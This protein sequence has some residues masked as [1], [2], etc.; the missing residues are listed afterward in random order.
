VQQDIARI[1][2][3]IKASSENRQRLVRELGMQLGGVDNVTDSA[4]Y[5]SENPVAYAL[6]RSVD[7][8]DLKLSELQQRLS[9]LEGE[10]ARLSARQIAARNGVSLVDPTEDIGPADELASPAAAETVETRYERIVD[11]ARKSQ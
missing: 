10:A 1:Q 8:E 3:Q 7:A 9:G 5:Q 6:I 11:Q 4:G 2:D